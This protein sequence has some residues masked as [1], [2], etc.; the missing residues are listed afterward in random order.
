MGILHL[1]VTVVTVTGKDSYIFR[2]GGSLL[3]FTC[4]CFCEGAA[5]YDILCIVQLDFLKLISRLGIFIDHYLIPKSI[6]FRYWKLKGIIHIG[7]PKFRTLPCQ[8]EHLPLLSYSGVLSKVW[9]MG[10]CFAD[11]C[12]WTRKITAHQHQHSPWQAVF[13]HWFVSS[14]I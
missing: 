12:W 2:L 9:K 10:T 5:S 6:Y 8:K 3:T 4:H 1:P 11:F 7:C 14:I 13:R